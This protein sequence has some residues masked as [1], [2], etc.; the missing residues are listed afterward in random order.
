MFMELNGD[1]QYKSIL[2]IPRYL[3][4]YQCTSK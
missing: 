3:E 2:K 1:Q 4:I